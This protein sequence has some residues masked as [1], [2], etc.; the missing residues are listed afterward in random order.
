LEEIRRRFAGQ[1]LL[2]RTPTALPAALPGVASYEH[3]NGGYHLMLSA[4]SD[5]QAVLAGLLS[6][7]D[8]GGTV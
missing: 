1:D 3:T 6:S 2:L 5:P 4:G 7:R 8:H